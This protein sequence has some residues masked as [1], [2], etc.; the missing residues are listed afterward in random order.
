MSAPP[1]QSGCDAP[2]PGGKCR[3]YPPFFLRG[4]GASIALLIAM[5]GARPEHNTGISEGRWTADENKKRRNGAGP[6]HPPGTPRLSDLTQGL[7]RTAVT[8]AP[9]VPLRAPG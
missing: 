5:H 2:P 1:R 7:G 4:G 9:P 8:P 6:R 3:P